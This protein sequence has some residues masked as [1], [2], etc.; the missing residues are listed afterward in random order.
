MISPHSGCCHKATP[1]KRPSSYLPW[2]SSPALRKIAPGPGSP[3]L[4]QAGRCDAGVPNLW[5]METHGLQHAD[6]NC[7]CVCFCVVSTL[8]HSLT[9]SHSLSLS[10]SPPSYTQ[11]KESSN[12]MSIL[13]HLATFQIIPIR[14]RHRCCRGGPPPVDLLDLFL[15]LRWIGPNTKTEES[16][17]WCCLKHEYSKI[18]WLIFIILTIKILRVRVIITIIILII[19]IIKVAFFGVYTSIPDKPKWQFK[20]RYLVYGSILKPCN[21]SQ[22]WCHLNHWDFR[23]TTKA[24]KPGQLTS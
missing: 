19:I 9:H 8:T 13:G 11:C 4:R 12:N 10:L 2:R 1:A 23:W 14:M 6:I 3:L 24:F 22:N 21:L 17:K 7:A 5:N 20:R 18:W 16:Q 15:N